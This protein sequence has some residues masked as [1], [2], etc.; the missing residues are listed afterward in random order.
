MSRFETCWGRCRCAHDSLAGPHG[1]EAR[2]KIGTFSSCLGQHCL[3][4]PFP[5]TQP[6]EKYAVSLAVE[7][8]HV[9]KPLHSEPVP[10]PNFSI[11][12]TSLSLSSRP[13][14]TY[15]AARVAS[16]RCAHNVSRVVSYPKILLPILSA[17]HRQVPGL[18]HR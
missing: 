1:W 10:G 5:G 18:Q 14:I 17:Y 8:N 4:K 16:Y 15:P 6:Y 13:S 3:L 7:P 2:N 9:A 11:Q 12:R